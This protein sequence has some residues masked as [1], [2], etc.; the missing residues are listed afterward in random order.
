MVGA[1]EA[2]SKRSPM[3]PVEGCRPVAINVGVKNLDEAIEF[4]EAVFGVRFE[5]DES[6]G[7]P[8]HARLVFGQDDSFFLF[9]MRERASDDPHRDH[10]TAF[11]FVVDDLEGAH[12]RA[13]QA[14]AVEHFG[15]MDGGGM[16][17]HSRFEDPSGNRIVL[18]QK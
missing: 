8:V 14:G 5:T 11:G 12:T 16:P 17:R 2:H 4:Y 15:P 9:N 13:V 6:E 7:R 1:A 10:I 18:W 3:Q